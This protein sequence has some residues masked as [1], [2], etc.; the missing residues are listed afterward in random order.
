MKIIR[1]RELKT[2]LENVDNESLKKKIKE[3]IE[4]GDDNPIDKFFKKIK[5]LDIIES[6]DYKLFLLLEEF[7]LRY[8]DAKDS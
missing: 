4:E 3:L 8:K 2:L 6:T 7:Y 5:E 1:Q